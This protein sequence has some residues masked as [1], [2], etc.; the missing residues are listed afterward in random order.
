MAT[1][2]GT[3]A[4]AGVQPKSFHVGVQA[5]TGTYSL[6]SLSAGDIMQICKVPNGAKILA[7]QRN[8][9][10]G[11]GND[12]VVNVGYD[13]SLSAFGSATGAAGIA[14]LTKGLPFDV[15]LSD[16]AVPQHRVINLSAATVTSASA[17][18]AVTLTVLFTKDVGK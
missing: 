12:V 18:G 9:A 1:L 4:A 15:S 11:T 17:T 14:F 6:P 16:G 10:A 7:I 5:V 3:A 8:F 2:T 13:D